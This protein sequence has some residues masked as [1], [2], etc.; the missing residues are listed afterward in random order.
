MAGPAALGE[1]AFI[2]LV[3]RFARPVR[4]RPVLGIGDDAAVLELPSGVQLLL[5]TDLLTEGIHF[6]IGYTPGFLLGRKALAVNLSD[7]AAMGGVPHSCVV[8]VGLPRATP[9]VYARAVAR[10]LAD[11]ARRSSVAIVGGDTCASKVAFVSVALLGFVEPKRAV[12]RDGARVGDAIY[13]T[14]RLGASGAGLRILRGLRGAAR[15]TG[16]APRARAAARRRAIRAHLDP[17]PRLK[18]GRA[19]GTTGL[20]GA[21][22]DLSDGLWED[23]P[24]LCR[25]SGVGAVI[26]QA[27]VPVDRDARLLLGPEEGLRC[28]LTGGE[29]YELLFT[30]RPRLE[31]HITRLGRRLE[32]PMTRIGEI[33]PS[34]LGVRVLTREGRYRPLP[35]GGFRHF[36]SR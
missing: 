2:D 32:L 21:M 33:V 26:L 3:A 5:T 15:R 6:K 27:A 28:A 25:S 13:V 12:R 30:A 36:P 9:P 11:M 23:L 31:K 18:A 35:A 10:G 24:R 34:R 14:G 4:P 7:V 19:L 29:D 8:A 22:I 17:T 1:Q 16:A 20:A